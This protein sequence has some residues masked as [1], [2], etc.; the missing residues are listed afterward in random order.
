MALYTHSMDKTDE[1]ATRIEQYI[2][3]SRCAQDPET[4][5]AKFV[6]DKGWQQE[7]AVLDAIWRLLDDHRITLDRKLRLAP[8]SPGS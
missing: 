5:F 3:G 7:S 2:L 1:L 6:S 8:L 4:I